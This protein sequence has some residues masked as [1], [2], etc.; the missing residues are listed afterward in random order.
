MQKSRTRIKIHVR[1]PI[2]QPLV[3]TSLPTRDLD[4]HLSDYLSNHR[5]PAIFAVNNIALIY[6]LS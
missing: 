5:P 6:Q 2:A 3:R 4:V 1:F